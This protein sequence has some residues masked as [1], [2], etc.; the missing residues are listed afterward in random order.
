MLAEID[1]VH[2]YV[3]TRLKVDHEPS[4]KCISANTCLKILY[5]AVLNVDVYD[6]IDGYHTLSRGHCNRT[7]IVFSLE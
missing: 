6:K 4:S 1:K 2:F 5:I 7:D 3:R